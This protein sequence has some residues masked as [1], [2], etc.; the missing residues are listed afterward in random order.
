[1]LCLT[2]R[3]LH[4]RSLTFVNTRSLCSPHSH[5]TA[6]VTSRALVRHRNKRL[7]KRESLLPRLSLPHRLY[8]TT[9]RISP[10]LHRTCSLLHSPCIPSVVQSLLTSPRASSLPATTQTRRPSI[11]TA[12][13]VNAY[14]RPL[15]SNTTTSRPHDHSL[16][17]HS[18]PPIYSYYLASTKPV[19][20]RIDHRRRDNGG[21]QICRPHAGRDVVTRY[22]REFCHYEERPECLD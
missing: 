12:N 22:R 15:A 17:A 2:L 16:C 11:D 9:W 13:N 7:V 18:R 19:V 20:G 10:I 21:R 5:E 4:R 3:S 14:V 8:P 6:E 1:V